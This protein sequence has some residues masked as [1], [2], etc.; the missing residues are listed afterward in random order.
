MKTP[1]QRLAAVFTGMTVVGGAVAIVGIVLGVTSRNVFL[2]GFLVFAGMLALLSGARGRSRAKWMI[3]ELHRR[4]VA[5]AG[6]PND[7][8][9]RFDMKPG[10]AALAGLVLAIVVTVVVALIADR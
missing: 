2:T 10:S 9:P 7:V 8:L 5:G 4:S 3:A 6:H 1:V